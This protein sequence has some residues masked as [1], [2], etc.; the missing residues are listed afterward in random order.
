[1]N[2]SEKKIP[3]NKILKVIYCLLFSGY[4]FYSAKIYAQNVNLEKEDMCYN[5]HAILEGRLKTPADLYKKDVHFEKGISCA[6]CHGGNYKSD[7]V[8]ISMDSTAGFIGKPAPNKIA[9]IC[10]KCHSKQYSKFKNS[11]HG[12]SVSGKGAPISSCIVCHGIH[13]ISPVKSAD[14]K[15]RSTNIVNTCNSCHGNASIIK[16]YN[17]NLPVNQLKDYKTSVH[18]KRLLKGDRK[19][20][21]CISCHN[22]HD[23]L[24]VSDENSPVNRI[25]VMGTCN[26]CHGDSLYMSGYKIPF[27]QYEKYKTSVHGKAFLEQKNPKAP[28]CINCHGSHGINPPGTE[29]FSEVCGS[30]HVINA[31]MFKNSPHHKAFNEKGLNHCSTCHNQHDINHPTDE[32]IGAGEKS[33]CVKCHKDDKGIEMSVY[34]KKMIDSLMSEAE[35]ANMLLGYAALKGMDVLDSKI[36]DN[37]LKQILITSRTSVHSSDPEIFKSKIE[38]GFKITDEAKDI[39][40]KAQNEYSLRK[41]LP[42]ISVFFVAVIFVSGLFKLRKNKKVKE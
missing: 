41:I 36:D 5:C 7:D 27:G 30:C 17:K 24:R 34:M 14:S 19:V 29:K 23:I 4:A 20:P 22:H 15:V 1:M 37:E 3:V 32:M 9:G 21:S 2:I 16:R 25:N 18:G 26:K 39:A 33:V 28:V 10:S 38:A 31:Q 12:N 13:D 11:V 35:E 6:S 8:D 42:W 40:E